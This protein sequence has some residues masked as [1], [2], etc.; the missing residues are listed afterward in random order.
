MAS[1]ISLSIIFSRNRNDYYHIS[2]SLFNYVS[3]KC[4]QSDDGNKLQHFDSRENE[5]WNKYIDAIS[6]VNISQC[7]YTVKASLTR[8]KTHL[9]QTSS[10][11][12]SILV[13][14]V[15]WWLHHY[16]AVIVSQAYKLFPGHIHFPCSKCL[17]YDLFNSPE[18]T[19]ICGGR[20]CHCRFLLAV[21]GPLTFTMGQAFLWITGVCS[22]LC[23]LRN[24]QSQV[25]STCSPTVSRQNSLFISLSLLSMK[26]GVENPELAEMQVSKST[27]CRSALCLT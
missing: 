25:N 1:Y 14:K 20:H 19:E 23:Q 24:L 13:Q 21:N 11:H 18:T 5:L 12:S 4:D 6:R 17:I 7:I 26:H 27:W 8:K 9:F 15:Q 3:W 2:S 16:V 22:C 10:I